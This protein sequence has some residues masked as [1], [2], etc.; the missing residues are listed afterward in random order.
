MMLSK[1]QKRCQAVRSEAKAWRGRE[2]LTENLSAQLPTRLPSN[3]LR[4]KGNPTRTTEQWL[5]IR[6]VHAVSAAGCRRRREWARFDVVYALT[7]PR[8]V[9]LS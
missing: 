8:R 5:K 1:Y 4:P 9:C 7:F 3:S 2:A 6:R